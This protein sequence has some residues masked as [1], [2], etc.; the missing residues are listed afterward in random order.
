[1]H[2]LSATCSLCLESNAKILRNLTDGLNDFNVTSRLVFN[3]YGLSV[4]PRRR[5]IT[6]PTLPYPLLSYLDC[7]LYS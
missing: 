2:A 6:Y 4:R 3:N 7:M 1:M 5:D